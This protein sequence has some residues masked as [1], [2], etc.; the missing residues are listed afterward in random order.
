MVLATSWF[1]CKFPGQQE[2]ILRYHTEFGARC[3]G[4]LIMHHYGKTLIHFSSFLDC[5]DWGIRGQD[6][7]SVH[8]RD[9]VSVIVS[10]SCHVGKGT[11]VEELPP[12]D[13]QWAY[14]CSI[15]MIIHGCRRTQAPVGGTS[16]RQVGL[17]CK[18]KG[19]ETETG[20]I[21]SVLSCHGFSFRTCLQVPVSR[22]CPGFPSVIDCKP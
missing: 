11:T 3:A 9:S 8:E 14:P 6:W 5:S 17:G 4:M 13:W 10:I 21:P 7:T 18:G 22:A 2:M 20:S 19:A 12:L 15:F 1:N 16:L